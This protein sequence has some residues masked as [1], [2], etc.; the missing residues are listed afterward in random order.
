MRRLAIRIRNRSRSTS[1]STLALNGPGRSRTPWLLSRARSPSSVWGPQCFSGRDW[2]TQATDPR[3][4]ADNRAQKGLARRGPQS[5]RWKV[6]GPPP[7]PLREGTH[8]REPVKGRF[9][10]PAGRPLTEPLRC[11][12]RQLSGWGE[13]WSGDRTSGMRRSGLP[14]LVPFTASRDKQNGTSSTRTHCSR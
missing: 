9:A 4:H 3:R 11:K 13:G 5:V 14:L 1:R 2:P 10:I 6:Q 12:F 8:L 7:N